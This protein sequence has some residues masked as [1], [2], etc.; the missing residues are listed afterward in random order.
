M[1]NKKLTYILVPLVGLIWGLVIYK[2]FIYTDDTDYSNPAS[3][4]KI[5]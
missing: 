2:I 5:Q 1:K 4:W 3:Y